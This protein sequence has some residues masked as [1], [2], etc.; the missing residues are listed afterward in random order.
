[1]RVGGA[2]DV[3]GVGFGAGVEAAGEVW[4]AVFGEGFAKEVS[5]VGS[6]G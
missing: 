5:S 6:V 4:G 2:E 3:F 1:M